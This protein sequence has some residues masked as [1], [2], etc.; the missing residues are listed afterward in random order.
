MNRTVRT[1]SAVQVAA[2][3]VL[4]AAA[5]ALIGV[6]AV[7]MLN[8]RAAVFHTRDVLT[9][10]REIQTNALQAEAAARRYVR[11]GEPEDAAA[12]TSTAVMDSVLLGELRELIGDNPAQFD[13]FERLQKIHDAGVALNSR[14]IDMRDSLGADAV[15]TID[16]ITDER[17]ISRER[18]DIISGM[19]R[20]EYAL[21]EQRQAQLDRTTR[22]LGVSL[23]GIW[24][25]TVAVVITGNRW[26]NRIGAARQRAEEALRIVNEQLEDR[27]KERTAELESSTQS[28]IQSERRYRDLVE[29]LP[30]AI[31]VTHHGN[32]VY[33]N[34]RGAQM[35]GG[36][37]R[38]DLLGRPL[39][40]LVQPEWRAQATER[41]RLLTEG[42]ESV[43]AAEETWIR[44][45]GTDLPVEVSA[46]SCV[47]DGRECV[48]TLVRDVRERRMAQEEI[49]RANAELEER[50][51]Q[52]TGEL[53]AANKE[54][55]AFCYSV[56]HDLRAPL[57]AIDGFSRMLLADHGGTL[58]AE[59]TRLLGVVRSN[60][61]RMGELIDDLLSFSRLSRQTT[62]SVDIDTP[63]LVR[64][65]VNGIVGGEDGRKIDVQIGDLPH[66]KGDHAMMRQVWSNLI[67]NA[68]TFTRHRPEAK[69]DI[70][71]AQENGEVSYYVRDNGVGFDMQYADKLFGVFQRFHRREEFEGTGVGLAIVKRVVERHGGRVWA[72]AAVDAGATFCFALPGVNDDQGPGRS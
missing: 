21:L 2:L 61:V 54:L 52:R 50:V 8:A 70:G 56:S 49:Q 42:S 16:Q 62:K 46:T 18:R 13:D 60:T 30:E 31:L 26:I 25:A 57:R 48:Q 72:D 1:T 33:T 43:A 68:V 15:R 40:T 59:G 20:M 44:L 10:L 19:D 67:L 7:K 6:G 58:S 53:Q 24:L 9:R 41:A 64:E 47:F 3:I 14:L 37:T 12:V 66:C 36:R 23:A 55:E 22:F 29:A 27:V 71:G 32:I 28:L 35:L 63:A 45:D 69:I 51:N 34:L 11:T 17:D 4:A 39:V 65:V 38:E 5:A